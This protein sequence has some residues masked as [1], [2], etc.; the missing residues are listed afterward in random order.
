MEA[1]GIAGEAGVRSWLALFDLSICA[2]GLGPV[3]SANGRGKVYF[4]DTGNFV[5]IPYS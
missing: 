1:A 5:H 3:Q 2:P 4:P